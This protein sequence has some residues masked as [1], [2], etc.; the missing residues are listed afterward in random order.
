[1]SEIYL[2][3]GSS[4]FRLLSSIFSALSLSLASSVGVGA[5]AVRLDVFAVD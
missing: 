5:L 2:L 3:S 1:M 4:F